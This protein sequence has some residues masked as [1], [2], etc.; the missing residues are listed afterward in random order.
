MAGRYYPVQSVGRTKC[1]TAG[2]QISTG[3]PCSGKTRRPCTECGLS[4]KRAGRLDR[5]LARGAR[6]VSELQAYTKMVTRAHRAGDGLRKV[7]VGVADQE[8]DEELGELFSQEGGR[9]EEL[10]KR[11]AETKTNTRHQSTRDDGVGVQHAVA[12][13]GTSL[14]RCRTAAVAEKLMRLVS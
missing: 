3:M 9:E 7:G 11:S 1:C 2:W 14:P 13:G 12:A 5:R 10:K 8:K 6:W 4:R